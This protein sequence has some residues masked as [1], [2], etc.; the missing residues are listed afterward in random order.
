MSEEFMEDFGNFPRKFRD[1][2][3]TGKRKPMPKS[4]TKKQLTSEE[5]WLQVRPHE[6]FPIYNA[7]IKE[8]P[9]SKNN[10]NAANNKVPKVI[11]TTP[12][13][14]EDDVEEG[15]SK[16]KQRRK[17]FLQS[18]KNKK[19]DKSH[20]HDIL[21]Q[22]PHFWDNVKAP[23]VITAKPKHTLKAPIVRL[24]KAPMAKYFE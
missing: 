7:R 4:E 9:N 24:R 14:E 15:K 23:A 10:R 8:G 19:R 22:R 16:R 13:F 6:T 12:S 18:K 20:E 17:A 11:K 2:L 5:A 21:V 1:A 3:A